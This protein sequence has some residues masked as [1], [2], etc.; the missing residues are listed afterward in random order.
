M[1]DEVKVEAVVTPPAPEDVSAVKA[2][3]AQVKADLDVARAESKAHQQNVTR[4]EQE[5][6]RQQALDGKV[7]SLEGKLNIIAEMLAEQLA[8]KEP[9]E[10]EPKARRKPEEYLARLKDAD[11]KSVVQKQAEAYSAKADEVWAKVTD[12]G[13]TDK[14]EEYWEIQAMLQSGI[15]ANLKRA[16][17][18]VDKIKKKVEV[19]TESPEQILKK[20]KDEV[21]EAARQLLESKGVLK[22]ET[23]GPS[24]GKGGILTLSEVDAMSQEE[25]HKRFPTPTDFYNAMQEGKIR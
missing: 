22:S 14:D 20:H 23:G 18:K 1:P 21:D 9:N 5:L 3:L 8:T 7:V 13:L 11:T 10:E 15:S 17:I 16:E 25:Y 4:K 19:V 12:S 2:E 24:G 6:K